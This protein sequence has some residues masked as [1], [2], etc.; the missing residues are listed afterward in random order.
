ML[1]RPGVIATTAPRTSDS[2]A[3]SLGPGWVAFTPDGIDRFAL[4]RAEARVRLAHG[5]LPLMLPRDSNMCRH[6]GAH[7]RLGGRTG[8]GA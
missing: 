8:F 6:R 7:A 5:A 2:I 3:S 1:S 4:D